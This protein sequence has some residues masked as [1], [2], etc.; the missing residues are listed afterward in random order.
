MTYINRLEI[1]FVHKT[2]RVYTTEIF[3]NYIWHIYTFPIALKIKDEYT[4]KNFR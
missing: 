3:Q 4:I 2:N 1:M